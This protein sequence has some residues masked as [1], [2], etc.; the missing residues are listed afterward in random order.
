MVY[1]KKKLKCDYKWAFLRN[2]THVHIII[3]FSF[4]F[5]SWW[6]KR[7]FKEANRKMPV[8]FSQ[9]KNLLTFLKNY[10][11]DQKSIICSSGELTRSHWINYQANP[12]C[13]IFASLHNRY[14][15]NQ[16]FLSTEDLTLFLEA[17]QGVNE[18]TKYDDEVVRWFLR[19]S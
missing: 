1:P 15:R 8:D 19:I 13:V 17:E 18:K 6:K 14:S 11:L 12:V 9:L 3:S 10:Q 7:K 2:E 5:F 4:F 16:D